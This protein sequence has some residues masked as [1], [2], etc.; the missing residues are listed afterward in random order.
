MWHEVKDY[1][2][3]DVAAAAAAAK[4]AVELRDDSVLDF[5]RQL[6]S[7]IQTVCG[8]LVQL[9]AKVAHLAD[10]EKA[11]QTT[12]QQADG[13]VHHIEERHLQR[14]RELELTEQE[15]RSQLLHQLHHRTKTNAAD[16]AG[17]ASSPAQFAE[18]LEAKIKG[19]KVK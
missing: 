10:M 9:R 19:T 3:E 15:L 18:Y 13:L 7:S 14:I 12:L 6:I 11:F 8:E 4:D 5:S 1:A 17:G 2:E 16:A